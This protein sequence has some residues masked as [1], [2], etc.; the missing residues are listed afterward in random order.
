MLPELFSGEDKVHWDDWI[1]HF[2]KVVA[3]NNWDD[4]TK[5]KWLP[6]RKCRNCVTKDDLTAT[7]AA[8]V[9][10]FEL[11]SKRNC[12][13]QSYSQER[14]KGKKDGLHMGKTLSGLLRKHT[15]IFHQRPKKG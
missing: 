5:K 8:L 6:V 10:R 13:E 2:Q 12:T 11:A 15:L 9:E 3:V 7:K 1:D 4:T 14:N